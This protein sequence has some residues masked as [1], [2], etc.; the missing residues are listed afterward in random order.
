MHFGKLSTV[1]DL[2]VSS[3]FWL[4]MDI[5]VGLRVRFLNRVQALWLRPLNCLALV[6]VL[7]LFFLLHQ[8]G[9]GCSLRDHLV[10]ARLPIFHEG[11]ERTKTTMCAFSSYT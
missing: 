8:G 1:L 10:N 5:V 4:E 7:L 3:V 9:Q 11:A 2:D 6:Q